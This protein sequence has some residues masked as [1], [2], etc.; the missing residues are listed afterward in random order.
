[1]GIGGLPQFAQRH[2]FP[3]DIVALTVIAFQEEGV[4]IGIVLL[5]F[6]HPGAVNGG[7][8]IEIQYIFLGFQN[9]W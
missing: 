4:V 3:I 7:I 5:L 8:D 6:W 2:G 9:L 1:M